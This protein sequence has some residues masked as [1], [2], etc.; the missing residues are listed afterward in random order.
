MLRAGSPAQVEALTRV[1]KSIED[2]ASAVAGGL[3]ADLERLSASWTGSASREF[4]RRVGSVTGYA[5]KL[6]D[7]A[8]AI[9]TGLSVM[10]AALRETQRLAEHPDEVVPALAFDGLLGG[11]LGTESAGLV[12]TAMLQEER[13][14]ARERMV[15]LVSGLAAQYGVVDH[16]TWPAE[17]TPAPAD[18]P[19]ALG[20]AL[21]GAGPVT[22]SGTEL[23]G[24]G[25]GPLSGAASQAAFIAAPVAAVA[26]ERARQNAATRPVA[27][28]TGASGHAPT[29][30]VAG[31][32]GPLGREAAPTGGTLMS[33]N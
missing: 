33:G 1:W 4:E 27:G 17:V 18:L 2:T 13:D 21:A 19:N 32:P 23:L 3:L 5:E 28:L 31:A 30:H 9:R 14:K 29:S 8:S 20:S 7:E 25:S 6:R 26:A 15:R 16:G 24:S 11:V 22:Q 12:G 10:S